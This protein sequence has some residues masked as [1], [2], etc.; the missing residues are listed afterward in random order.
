[1]LREAAGLWFGV[2][3]CSC[4]YEPE[5]ISRHLPQSVSIFETRSLTETG[6]TD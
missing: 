6:L 3:L 1:M 2:W 4:V 5:V